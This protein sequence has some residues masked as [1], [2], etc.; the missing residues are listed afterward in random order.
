MIYAGVVEKGSRRGTVL[1]FP[2]ANVSFEGVESGI[3]AARVVIDDVAYQAAV[4]ADQTRKLLE[5]HLIEFSL[6]GQGQAGGDL[7]GKEIQVQLLKKTRDSKKFE[8]DAALRETI[9][10][11]I[12]AVKDYLSSQ[13]K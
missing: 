7:Y 3:Y 4:Y 11:D 12:Q 8:D 13:S 2:T 5:A 6:P 10:Q 9:A 1:G